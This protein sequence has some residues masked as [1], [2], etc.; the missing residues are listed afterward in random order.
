M[1]TFSFA[2]SNPCIFVG[3][4]C[5]ASCF[6]DTNQMLTAPRSK[7]DSINTFSEHRLRRYIHFK[8]NKM[9]NVWWPLSPA[10]KPKPLFQADWHLYILKVKQIL[11]KSNHAERGN[12]D[13]L[14]GAKTATNNVKFTSD[15]TTLYLL[16][17]QQIEFPCCG[18][19]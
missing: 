7:A 9:N 10:Q 18:F 3:L 6:F 11:N 1:F 4:G 19:M 13:T 14:R 2:P 16:P 12:T 8:Q 17:E 15:F 5:H